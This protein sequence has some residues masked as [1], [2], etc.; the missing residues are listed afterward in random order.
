[1]CEIQQLYR[2]TALMA[3]SSKSLI[4]KGESVSMSISGASSY[5]WSTGATGTLT[6]V[7]PTSQL[8]V[9]VQAYNSQTGC[10]NTFTFTT[11]VSNC[12]YLLDDKAPSG[13]YVSSMPLV[14]PI[15]IRASKDFSNLQLFDLSGKLQTCV[16]KEEDMQFFD[17]SSGLYVLRGNYLGQTISTKIMVQ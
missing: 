13:L 3:I 14:S 10:A 11:K 2:G 12:T 8:F 16:L 4:C 15:V 5:T 6:T 9:E 17:L 1:M 7:Y